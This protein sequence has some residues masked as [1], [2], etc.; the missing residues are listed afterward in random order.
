MK[1]SRIILLKTVIQANHTKKEPL[2]L[3]QGC[4][5]S[6]KP[7]VIQCAL[8]QVKSRVPV[9]IEFGIF[10]NSVR[11]LPFNVTP[12]GS[13]GLVI[14]WK[15]GIFKE[16]TRCKTF[17]TKIIEI[18]LIGSGSGTST[19][20]DLKFLVNMRFFFLCFT[21]ALK[22]SFVFL[23]SKHDLEHRLIWN[24]NMVFLS[25]FSFCVISIKRFNLFSWALLRQTE[26]QLVPLNH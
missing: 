20:T 11:S 24:H 19:F 3:G 23:P 25:S 15:L 6:H 10:A 5:C 7:A 8:I 26:S 12:G 9:D 17:S 2:I 14:G 22:W 18:L 4:G 21:V 13:N 16:S 1:D